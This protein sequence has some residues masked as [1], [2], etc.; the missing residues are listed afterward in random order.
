VAVDADAIAAS[1]PS[2]S[3]PEWSKVAETR[4]QDKRSHERGNK[5]VVGLGSHLATG[6]FHILLLTLV[7]DASVA[8]A[9]EVL[10]EAEGF[11]HSGGWLQDPQFLDVMGSPYLL[12]HGLG[13]PVANAATEVDFPQAGSYRLW[14]RTKDW[15]PAHH[16]GVF[17]VLVDGSELPVSFGNQGQGWVWQDGGK[18]AIKNR[19]VHIELH[20]LTGFDGRC[21]ALFFTTDK[22]FLPPDRPDEKMASWRR[23]L[24]GL[25][26]TPLSAE[27]QGRHQTGAAAPGKHP[28][29]VAENSQTTVADDFDVVVVGGGLAGCSAA[30]AA[31]RRGLEVALIQNRPVLGGNGSPEIGITPRG[32]N[33]SLVREIAGFDREQ[34]LRAQSNIHL[35]L[36]WHAFRVQRHESRIVSV[37]AKHTTGNQELRFA[38]SLFI[39][40]TGNGS[41]GA[42]AG[43]EYRLGREAS[44]EFH[45]SLAPPTAD[46][47]H[48]GNTVVFRTRTAVQPSA[49]PGVPWAVEVAKDFADLGGQVVDGHDNVDGLTHFW[50]YGQWLDPIQDAEE[51]RDHLFR[52]VY[53]TFANAKRREPQKNANLELAWVG[54]VPATGE[55]RRLMG[56]YLLTENDIRSQQAFPDAVAVC[57]GHFCLHYPGDKYDF[58]L[59]DW[60]WIPVQPYSIPLRCLYSRN[61]DNLL[62]AGKHISLTHV[63]GSSTKTMLNGGQT[64]VAAGGTAFLCRKYQT[65]PRGV[66]QQ[67]LAELQKI[68]GER[69]VVV[70][71]QLHEEHLRNPGRG[72]LFYSTSGRERLPDQADVLFACVPV[73]GQVEKTKGQYDWE[74]PQIKGVADLAARHQRRWAIRIMPSFQGHKQPIPGWLVDAGVK[75]LAPDPKWLAHF[76]QQ[77]LYEPQW[78]HPLY[79]DAHAQFVKAYAQRFDNQPGLEFIDMRYY[80][81]WGEGHRF[82]ATEPWPSDVNK[83][84]LMKRFIDMY[85]SFFRK[86]PLVVQTARDLGEPYPEGTAIDYALEKGCWMRRDGFGGYLDEK[87]TRLIQARWRQHPLVA[88]NGAA[89]ADYLGG[90]VSGWTIDR[91]VD[92]MLA[93]HVSYFPM[94]WGVRD[95]EALL[96]Q[97]PDLVKRAS[98]RMGY[99]LVVTQASWPEQV[100]AGESFVLQAI[101][102]NTAVAAFPFRWH[103]AVYLLATVRGQPVARAAHIQADPR[104]WVEDQGESL[105][106]TISVPD[107]L[108]P[109]RYAVAVAIEDEHGVPAI[110]LGID[111]DDG[112]KRFVLGQVEVIKEGNLDRLKESVR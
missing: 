83:R 86:T 99:R 90:K 94:G 34:V 60:K 75:L 3:A 32:E 95:W 11:S 6:R 73:W 5:S 103:P 16:P 46:K 35:F 23:R 25:P 50:E 64:G 84:E 21:D 54:H 77:D 107:Q 53:G 42:W 72:F 78:W 98:L 7:W 39:D 37:D 105:L 9:A 79:R 92:E 56:D 14:V 65:T 59:G 13:K 68:L 45:E 110:T 43:A 108:Q 22:D 47:M 10:V 2:F 87:E 1:F 29:G 109:G 66:Y 81:F 36:G 58:R 30:L 44:A 31:A 88:E 8:S 55:S 41:I 104:T 111:G 51:I 52:A 57:S 93:H 102:R 26:D 89:Y 100:K 61:I 15:V 19:R 63:A 112:Q 106:F 20:D 80:G 62:M 4:N 74:I 18:V 97:R 27:R 85:V 101:W 40:C 38:A 24:L 67:H 71:P 96:Q 48:H 69:E 33:R 70:R 91:V 28:R 76:N 82:G 12:A 17:R 49:F